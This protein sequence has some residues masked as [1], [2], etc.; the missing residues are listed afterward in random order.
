[1]VESTC[2]HNQF[3]VHTEVQRYSDSPTE[4]AKGFSVQIQVRCEQCKRVFHFDPE[5]TI[6]GHDEPGAYV[7]PEGWAMEVPIVPA[8]N[9]N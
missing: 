2:L 9:V 8:D 7:N 6:P 5:A 1:M 3:V 4:P